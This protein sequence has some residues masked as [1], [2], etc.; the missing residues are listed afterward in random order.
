[1]LGTT[2][3]TLHGLI[4]FVCKHGQGGAKLK[5]TEKHNKHVM[6]TMV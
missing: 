1:M 4:M 2:G 5:L 3:W 6:D